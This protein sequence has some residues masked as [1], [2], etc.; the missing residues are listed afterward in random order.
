M[1]INL[2][3]I[4]D[5]LLPGLRGLTG[6]YDNIE[7]KYDQV[8]DTDKSNMA[9][10]R[11]VEMAYLPFA[12]LKTEG[13][14]VTYDN[15][16]GERF[17]W[18]QEHLE[19]A[20]GYAMTR[21]SIDDNLYKSEFKPAN[22]GLAKSFL[23]LKEAIAANILN[24][25]L[26]YNPA[27]GGDG[28]PLFSTSHPVDGGT[29]SNTFATPADLNEASL[30]AANNSIRKQF[31][32]QRGLKI[33][34]R[35]RKLIVPIDLGPVADRLM[36]TKLR[37]GTGDN[38]INAILTSNG[39]FADGFMVYD[40]LTS[41]FAWFILT[42]IRGLLHL[43]RKPFETDM[44]V[45]FTTQNLLVQGYERYSFSYNNPRAAFGTFPTS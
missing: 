17:V 25:G 13:A 24:T 1:A 14:A 15:N 23:L 10:E 42:N 34:A 11:T 12:Q 39:G 5:L 29:Y 7:R 16:A 27:V 21:K 8:F 37:V 36:N 19:V 35:G 6:I 43:V 40:Y 30:L 28:Q 33:Y 20:L 4:R 44:Q 26:V 41:P 31:V 2:S 45:D 38:D 22:L 32:D 18:N 9:F 3:S